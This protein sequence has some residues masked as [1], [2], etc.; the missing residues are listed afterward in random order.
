M[1]SRGRVGRPVLISMVF[2]A[3]LLTVSFVSTSVVANPY[4]G[5]KVGDYSDYSVTYWF[6][7]SYYSLSPYRV[8]VVNISTPVFPGHLTDLALNFTWQFT[9]GTW[10]NMGPGDVYL[11]NWS[12]YPVDWL[13]I[14]WI[15]N[16]NSTKGHD[17]NY[18]LVV[19]ETTQMAVAGAVR[20]VNHVSVVT[21]DYQPDIYWDNATG[22]L[23]KANI[24]SNV[25][26][27]R[28]WTNVTMLDTNMWSSEPG[29]NGSA[30]SVVVVGGVALAVAAVAIA[31]VIVKRRRS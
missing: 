2:I 13:D 3:V 10:A 26:Y 16:A 8:T 23:V 9:N 30:V 5:V 31:V 15:V 29:I 7:G 25:L 4:V 17:I 24:A 18:P 27:H 11:G 21:G 22:V 20:T 6:N 1:A 19:N 14:M 12:V 28:I